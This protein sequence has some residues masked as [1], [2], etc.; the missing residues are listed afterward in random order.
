MTYP[1]VIKYL[2]SLTNYEKNT[3]YSYKKDLTLTRIRGFLKL[4]GNPQD[5]LRI[6][7]IA[8]TKGKGSTCAFVAHMLRESGLSVGL[9]TSPHLNDFRERI[10]ILWPLAKESRQKRKDFEGMISKAELSNLVKKL[11]PVINKYNRYSKHGK[12][13]FFEVYTALAFLYFKRKRID[14]VVLETG[15]GGRLDAT[16]VTKPL[17]CGITPI[18]LE[19]VQILGNTLSKI[20][21]EKAAI[22]KHPGTIVIS[23]LQPK[24]VQVVIYNQCKKFQAKF[25]EIGKEIK[26]FNFKGERVI[27]GLKN[28][29][30]NLQFNLS[31]EHQL[32]NA[33]LAVGLVESLSFYGYNF[34]ASVLRRG[35]QSTVWPGRFEL[36]QRNPLVILDGAQNLASAQALRLA[37]EDN[38]STKDASTNGKKYRKLILVLGIS[39]DKDISGICKTLSPLADAVIL[40]QAATPRAIDPKELVR[41]FKRKLYLTFS[42]KEAKL[43]A[44]KLAG[45]KD[46]ILVTGS[47]FVVGEFR[48][49]GK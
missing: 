41:Y 20:A 48:D 35:L 44:K 2:N 29:Y 18:S 42:V 40:T 1:V 21:A 15:L 22:I 10:R 49:V 46:L 45:K 24:E 37:I 36:I 32:A 23:A 11:K 19:H 7:H 33:A 28:D 3:N 5:A 25:C 34:K 4:L 30:K 27:K 38:F 12:L 14:F 43:L 17:V 13:S 26:Y 47:L 8:G 6:I 9:Y 16:N 39:S 31:G